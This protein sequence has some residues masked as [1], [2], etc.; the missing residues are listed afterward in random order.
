MAQNIP[1]TQQVKDQN[2]A[3]YESKLNQTSPLTDK[4]FLRVQSAV[5]ALIFTILFKL[6]ADRAKQAL[7]ITATEDG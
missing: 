4:A 3:N 5:E 1:T 2:L 6:I 7:A